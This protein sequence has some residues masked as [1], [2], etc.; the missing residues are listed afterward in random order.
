MELQIIAVPCNPNFQHHSI[1]T[2]S[3]HGEETQDFTPSDPFVNWEDCGKLQGPPRT[4]QMT[5]KD[6][7]QQ[8]QHGSQTRTA[9]ICQG[10]T[11]KCL[12]DRNNWSTCQGTRFLL[13]KVSRW[14]HP[15]KDPPDDQIRSIPSHFKLETQRSE[16]NLQEFRTSSNLQSF[17]TMFPEME[18]PALQTGIL[19]AQAFHETGMSSERQDIATSSQSFSGVTKPFSQVVRSAHYTKGVPPKRFSPLRE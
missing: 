10:S 2:W 1:T 9:C 7:N 11:W 14:F 16:R 3:P 12:E 6:F 13:G 4:H 19:V 17:Q 15:E 5:A 18:Q 8:L